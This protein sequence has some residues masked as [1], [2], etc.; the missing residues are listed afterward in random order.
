MKLDY[1]E[2]CGFRGIRNQL[3]ISFAPAFTIISGRNGVGKSTICDAIEY[4]VTGKINKYALDKA[5]KESIDDY[6]WWRGE[7]R[8]D[9][10]YV[11]VGFIKE[12]GE[13]L[14]IRRTRQ[15]DD[16]IDQN[17]I[18]EIFCAPDTKPHDALEYM[19][20]TSI[21][22]DELIASSSIEMKETD[23]FE[24][25]SSSL[26][27][28]EEPEYADKS[29]AVNS[30]IETERKKAAHAHEQLR[31]VLN[32]KLADLTKAR[33]LAAKSGDLET[34]NKTIERFM[35]GID[36]DVS[37]RVIAARGY[38]AS[39]HVRLNEL[40]RIIRFGFE[41]A[42]QRKQ[43]DE[44]SSSLRREAEN[45]LESLNA[46]HIQ[47]ISELTEARKWYAAEEEASILAS[48][49]VN[50]ISA[51]EYIGLTDGH[52]PLC[53][54]ERSE[55]EYHEGMRIAK[56]RLSASGSK[57][58]EAN[59]KVKL[60]SAQ[61]NGANE[62]ISEQKTFL[63]GIAAK[64]KQIAD[65]EI[66]Y[67]AMLQKA[68][69]ASSL[70][71]S[72][73]E[74]GINKMKDELIRLETAILTLEASQSVRKISELES[75]ISDLKK[76]VDLAAIRL[77]KLNAAAERSKTI[78]HTIRSINAEM[79]D[80]RL[81]LMSPLL[82]ELY[83]RL[84]PHTDWKNIEWRIRGDVRRF[85]SLRVGEDLNPQFMFSSGQRRI[86][87]LAFLLSVHLS[88]D[89]CRW[90]TLVLDDP[91]QHIDDYRAINLVELLSSIQTP[92]KQII[93]TI[94][95]NDL[96]ELFCRRLP[97]DSSCYGKLVEIALDGEGQTSI[98]MQKDYAS[99]GIELLS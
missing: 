66:E 18:E 74:D 52:C 1:V 37:Q 40:E 51:G 21:I 88:R 80:E 77:T 24:L 32:E 69:V 82:G 95:D 15:A 14:P 65:R 92:Q 68:G 81:A 41:V 12:N 47:L 34:A 96:A 46:G 87:G 85:L 91:V 48:Q 39:Q 73:I 53:S 54:A 5:A 79:V 76:S 90:K 58:G 49:L 25:V 50:L 11:E 16:S 42:E 43:L 30:I 83:Q 75:T 19:C 57:L 10:N 99:P 33:D 9:D 64:E 71:T 62:Q 28:F 86:T 45:R 20:R 22:R 63:Q 13:L 29:S 7:G 23:L 6:I 2:V 36:A 72:E 4:A 31:S 44:H 70:S 38:L 56:S 8:A 98:T 97:S 61:L 17:N 93:C 27:A 94:E 35:P 26:G 60:L 67:T 89:W 78:H 59:E 55:S 3:R 84:R